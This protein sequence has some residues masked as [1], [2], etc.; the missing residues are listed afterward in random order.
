MAALH[1]STHTITVHDMPLQCDVYDTPDYPNDSPVFLFF[2]AGGL[3]C[4]AR[5]IMPPWLVQLCFRRKW[6]LVSAS[7]RLLPQA[8][9]DAMLADARAAYE[10][11]QT[12]G[13]AHGRPVIV[14]G[15]SA[16]E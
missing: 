4:G 10:F 5:I 15:A 7:Y 6:P 13:G 1:K 2:H 16:G 11:A 12:L 9:G 3:V 8:N 14:G